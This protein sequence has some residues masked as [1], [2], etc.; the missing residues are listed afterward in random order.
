MWTKA[1][2]YENNQSVL[3]DEYISAIK[4]GPQSLKTALLKHYLVQ[5]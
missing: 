2:G 4:K 5:N 3:F 1:L